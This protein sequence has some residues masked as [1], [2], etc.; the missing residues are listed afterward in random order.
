MTQPNEL[1]RV[2][3]Q[4]LAQIKS[5]AMEIEDNIL[6]QE[7]DRALKS[8]ENFE[9][10]P[11]QFLT[12]AN[13]I[14]GNLVRL[15]G[16]YDK[17]RSDLR[18]LYADLDEIQQS[19]ATPEGLVEMLGCLDYPEARYAAIELIQAT[20]LL[21]QLSRGVF[22]GEYAEWIREQARMALRDL[23]GT[24]KGRFQA[25][26]A[27]LYGLGASKILRA[28]RRDPTG[29]ELRQMIQ[30]EQINYSAIV[31]VAKR[32]V[33]GLQQEILMPLFQE[34]EREMREGLLAYIVPP[35]ERRLDD[36]LIRK[37]AKYV[38]PELVIRS[39]L[40]TPFEITLKRKSVPLFA[41]FLKLSDDLA[42]LLS[43][44]PTH[45]HQADRKTISKTI[46]MIR[47]T[48]K[49]L[50][51]T[52]A[53]RDLSDL[54]DEEETERRF[55]LLLLRK[56]F[57]SDLRKR[58]SW[59]YGQVSEEAPLPT[60]VRKFFEREIVSYV[61]DFAQTVT[62]LSIEDLQANLSAW[63]RWLHRIEVQF[64]ISEIQMRPFLRF[65]PD[66]FIAMERVKLHPKHLMKV[67][68]I[69]KRRKRLAAIARRGKTAENALT[70]LEALFAYLEKRLR[71]P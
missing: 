50:H 23:L 11:D 41:N 42:R 51:E 31:S 3:K 21:A 54:K 24:G 4:V 63:R 39:R 43:L 10:D 18:A 67:N 12:D 60:E 2:K 58:I 17:R 70:S 16:E 52:S 62:D 47:T 40:A 57:L 61:E 28:I 44:F 69:L 33:V 38:D 13:E 46:N 34:T 20:S 56:E 15:L 59:V 36:T 30:E 7:T 71:T 68:S 27:T 8:L 37:L 5:V 48:V 49:E 45:L 26:I 32:I 53:L 64:N 29:G 65:A 55:L 25:D 35:E 22:V 14:L 9:G 19:A 1:Q 6:R 66:N